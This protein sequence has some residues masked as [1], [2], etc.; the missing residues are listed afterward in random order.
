MLNKD[1]YIVLSM[2][3]TAEKIIKYSGSYLNAEDFYNNDRD[4]DA[5]MM[6]FVVLGEQVGKLTEDYK[7]K[8]EQIN[9]QKIN[10][11]RNI[12]AHQYFGI[13]VDTVWQIIHQ[14]IPNLKQQLEELIK[15]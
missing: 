1:Y 15:N 7:D 4:F 13:N 3:E 2:I 5:T 11:L 12:I 14:D 8:N 9:W 10:G 6:N